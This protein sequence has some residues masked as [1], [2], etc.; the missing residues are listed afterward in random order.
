MSIALRKWNIVGVAE[1]PFTT[2]SVAVDADR[3][4]LAFGVTKLRVVAG[5]AGY[6]FLPG[7]NRVVEQQAAQFYF[8]GRGGVVGGG[9][10]GCGQCAE[11]R[12][13]AFVRKRVW[14]LFPASVIPA[15]AA[16]GHYGHETKQDEKGLVFY[17]H[18]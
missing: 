3:N 13:Q 9:F 15:T 5:G 10:R 14:R 11:E 18:G 8:F 2:E 17:V 12:N 1:N 16:P 7:Q 4:I 6:I